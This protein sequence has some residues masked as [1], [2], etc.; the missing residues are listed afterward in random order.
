MVFHCI[1]K[2]R[3]CEIAAPCAVGLIPDEAQQEDEDEPL[4]P[5]VFDGD[6]EVRF[7]PFIFN[8]YRLFSF[9][10]GSIEL[11]MEKMTKN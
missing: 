10:F 2:P 3:G 7:Q 9:R 5:S 11:L 4:P 6:F 8:R 1:P